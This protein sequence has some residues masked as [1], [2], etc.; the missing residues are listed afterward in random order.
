MVQLRLLDVLAAARKH[1]ALA[2]RLV[3]CGCL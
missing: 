2:C 1:V 3:C